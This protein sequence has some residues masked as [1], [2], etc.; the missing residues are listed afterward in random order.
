MLAF[1]CFAFPPLPRNED[2][3]FP[4]Y[5]AQSAGWTTAKTVDRSASHAD[6]RRQGPTER[7]AGGHGSQP[8]I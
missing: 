3:A 4:F 2:E 5:A 7:R 8:S 1:T 6:R